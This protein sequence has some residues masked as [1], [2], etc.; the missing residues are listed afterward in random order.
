[1]IRSNNF[2]I[3]CGVLEQC[4]ICK[5][6]NYSEHVRVGNHDICYSSGIDPHDHVDDMLLSDNDDD[7]IW[8]VTFHAVDDDYRFLYYEED[9]EELKCIVPELGKNYYFDAMKLHAYIHKDLIDKF[10][11]LE[12]W[13]TWSP[14]GQL[15]CIYSFNW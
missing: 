6:H 11:D 5:P 3:L 12:F 1:M 4:K 14:D 7:G 9:S 2:E 15:H 8:D 13:K 10:H